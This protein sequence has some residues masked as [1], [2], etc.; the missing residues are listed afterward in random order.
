[1]TISML[2]WY[3]AI[4]RNIAPTL[5]VLFAQFIGRAVYKLTADDPVNVVVTSNRRC[6]QRK[7]YEYLIHDEVDERENDDDRND[8][9]RGGSGPS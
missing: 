9:N 4:V 3:V 2:V 6:R 1:M 8:F 5:R 7:N